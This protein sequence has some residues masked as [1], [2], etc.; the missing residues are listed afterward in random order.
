MVLQDLQYLEFVFLLALKISRVH[1]NIGDPVVSG[2]FQGIRI[3][4]ITDDDSYLDVLY[5]TVLDIIYDG[6]QVGTSSRNKYCDVSGHC[7][8]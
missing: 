8:P 6:L 1:K 3:G 5:V 2:T 4:H 7:Y